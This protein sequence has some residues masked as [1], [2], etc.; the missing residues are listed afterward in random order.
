[1]RGLGEVGASWGAT[2]IINLLPLTQ[3]FVFGWWWWGSGDE[4]G[5]WESPAASE[6]MICSS[7]AVSTSKGGRRMRCS[8]PVELDGALPWTPAGCK[9]RENNRPALRGPS[10][11]GCTWAWNWMRGAIKRPFE[12]TCFSFFFSAW[13]RPQA[14]TT[15]KK[16]QFFQF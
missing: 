9:Q 8:A 16:K 2:A 3:S 1:M 13:R 12:W 4:W 14:L 6:L 10:P 5:V 7:A 15:V 11:V